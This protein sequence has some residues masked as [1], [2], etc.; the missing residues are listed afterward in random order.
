MY[1]VAHCWHV[2]LVN[3]AFAPVAAIGFC[4]WQIPQT[5][6]DCVPTAWLWHMLHAKFPFPIVLQ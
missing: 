6:G 4:G 2:A 1:A 5:Y 3:S